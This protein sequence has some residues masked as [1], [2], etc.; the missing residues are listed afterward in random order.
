MKTNRN[1][2][3]EPQLFVDDHHGRYMGQI[4]WKILADRYKKQA[5]KVLTAEDIADLQ[6]PDS[7]FYDE[8]CDKLCNVVFKTETG[9]KI[10]LVYAEGGIW[11]IPACFYRSKAANDFFGY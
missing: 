4:A 7:E 10:S 5:L 3:T 6:N 1:T 8:T 2:I 9:Q 11:V